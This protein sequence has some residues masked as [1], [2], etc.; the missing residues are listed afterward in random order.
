MRRVSQGNRNKRR[1]EINGDF[2]TSESDVWDTVLAKQVDSIGNDTVDG[3]G[4]H[5]KIGRVLEKL[6]HGRIDTEL[7]CEE[8]IGSKPGETPKSLYEETKTK[9]PPDATRSSATIIAAHRNKYQFQIQPELLRNQ[10]D[11]LNQRD[12]LFLFIVFDV[13]SLF[14]LDILGSS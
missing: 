13:V 7:I 2:D 1:Q 8:E 9:Q 4:H 11:I 5:W 12:L 10:T 6:Q 14:I 3:L